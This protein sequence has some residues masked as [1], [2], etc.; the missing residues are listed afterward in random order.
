MI[1]IKVTGFNLAVLSDLQSCSAASSSN[2]N[3]PMDHAARGLV[4]DTSGS[5]VTSDLSPG[6]LNLMIFEEDL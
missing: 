2:I 5:S 1:T 6:R 3:A 4:S